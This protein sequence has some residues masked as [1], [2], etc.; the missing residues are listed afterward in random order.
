[1]G[2]VR[3]CCAVFFGDLFAD[4]A[5]VCHSTHYSVY[6][7]YILWSE[8]YPGAGL[9]RAGTSGSLGAACVA[10]MGSSA[11][12]RITAAAR[13]E[14]AT[15]S[16]YPSNQQQTRHT[17]NNMV[18]E[19]QNATY[20]KT[21]HY[22]IIERFILFN[23]TTSFVAYDGSG[24]TFQLQWVKVGDVWKIL[25]M[26]SVCD[27][28][29]H[30]GLPPA[31]SEH[32]AFVS[33]ILSYTSGGRRLEA[34][35]NAFAGSAPAAALPVWQPPRRLQSSV[36]VYGNLD[37]SSSRLPAGLTTAAASVQL[38]WDRFALTERIS[39][40]SWLADE[41]RVNDPKGFVWGDMF[42]DDAIFCIYTA[43]TRVLPPFGEIVEGATLFG[44]GV[45][46]GPGGDEC[47]T[48]LG[49]SCTS[50]T[51]NKGV[52]AQ[53]AMAYMTRNQFGFSSAA[54]A[55]DQQTRHTLTN[56]IF[57]EQT[58]TTAVTQVYN[59][60][61]RMINGVAYDGSF[62][63]YQHHWQ[64][65]GG[66]WKWT[67]I[68]AINHGNG[69][70]GG[71][72][73]PTAFSTFLQ[74]LEGTLPSGRRQL[75]SIG[76]PAAVVGSRLL[77]NPQVSR[78]PPAA[79]ASLADGSLTTA[80]TM[81]WDRFE[82]FERLNMYPFLADSTRLYEPMGWLWGDLLYN[83][84]TFCIGSYH[85][86]NAAW[87]EWSE[88]TLANGAAGGPGGDACSAA[89]GETCTSCTPGMGAW[90]PRA[91]QNMIRAQFGVGGGMQ[92]NSQQTRHTF[93]NYVFQEQTLTNAETLNYN[94]VE[95]YVD[96]IAYDGSNFLYRM[97]WLKVSNVWKVTKAVAINYG[98][99]HLGGSPSETVF[100]EFQDRIDAF[101]PAVPTGVPGPST[102]GS[103]P[104]RE[105]GAPLPPPDDIGLS[106]LVSRMPPVAAA[107]P[108]STQLTM[109]WD[110]F[111]VMERLHL[112]GWLLDGFSMYGEVDG[113]TRRSRS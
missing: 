54:T 22:Q 3:P 67:A 32:D 59:T 87:T 27:G 42:A 101:T 46:G 109:L 77:L 50:C 72:P 113:C 16:T 7:P 100:T 106:P 18:V 55:N 82:M 20:M 39:M 49:V 13:A 36:P 60:L 97:E 14:F 70:L 81:L 21:Q 65:Q 37:P 26:K 89:I 79:L 51:P 112:Y 52:Y 53:G 25:T 31:K 85:N 99:A 23:D 5:Y 61:E 57:L 83:D 4:D 47:S 6:A 104:V 29:G 71:F 24:Y 56:Y 107:A 105:C 84:A 73:D 58:A 11:Q 2:F 95:R 66:V 30:L 86:V 69:H 74:G 28:H 34:L 48:A 15:G 78:I 41:L 9:T 35:H 64:K 17:V 62:F 68:H 40:Y 108:R 111:M 90:A 43:A 76:S 80:V 91:M 88:I 19:L 75:G 45:G 38:L 92:R 8:I 110:R 44:Q 12:E 33:G 93:S 94:I 1:M 102:G 10:N 63:L 98:N 103:G 96:G